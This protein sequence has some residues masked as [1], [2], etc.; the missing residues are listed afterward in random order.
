MFAPE[1]LTAGTS[2]RPHLATLLSSF[3]LSSAVSTKGGIEGS[4]GGSAFALDVAALTFD[5]ASLNGRVGR[6]KRRLSDGGEKNPYL[7][8]LPYQIMYHV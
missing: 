8:I 6:S 7:V 5:R 4:C 3:F 2:I 1:S